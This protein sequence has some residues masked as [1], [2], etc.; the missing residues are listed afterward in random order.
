MSLTSPLIIS[1]IVIVITAFF[2]G[3]VAVLIRLGNRKDTNTQP[4]TQPQAPQQD[5]PTQ[6]KSNHGFIKFLVAIL[7]IGAIIIGAVKLIDCAKNPDNSD[8]AIKP[9]SRSAN[10]NDFQLEQ[11]MEASILNLKDSYIIIPYCDISNLQITFTYYDSSGNILINK[12]KDVGSVIENS[13]YTIT[14]E[15][16]L[17]EFFSISKYSYSVTGGTVSYFK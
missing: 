2:V 17:S 14:V 8:G 13:S 9:F 7:I 6:T 15:H 3:I 12:T 11:S 4:S 16:T 1:L 10:N 5:S